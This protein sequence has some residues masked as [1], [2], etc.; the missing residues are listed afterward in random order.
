MAV[1]PIYIIT[2]VPANNVYHTWMQLLYL[3]YLLIIYLKIIR[4]MTPVNLS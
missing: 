1:F 3:I 4:V 2:E